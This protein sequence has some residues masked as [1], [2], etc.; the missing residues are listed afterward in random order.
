MKNF[1]IFRHGQ[2]DYNLNKIAQGQLDIELNA[3]GKKQ[4]LELANKLKDINL[5]II[6]SSPLKRAVQ[7][8]DIVASELS[9]GIEVYDSLKEFNLGKLEGK[10]LN[11]MPSK[12]MTSDIKFR[13]E[14]GESREEV[15]ERFFTVLN[16]LKYLDV[17]NI[18]IST[19]GIIMKSLLLSFDDNIKGSLD[20]GEFIHLTYEDG[21]FKYNK[22]EGMRLL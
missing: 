11:T 19:H 7:T 14:G 8:A 21:K 17:S 10:Q 15:H 12:L 4:A 20:N 18:G 9:L 1:Y 2:T 16:E 5:E 6:C 3:T 13:F 22:R